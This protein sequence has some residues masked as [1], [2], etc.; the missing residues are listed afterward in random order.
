VIAV[1]EAARNVVVSGAQP[2]AISDCLNFGNPEKPEVMWQFQQAVGG[3]RDACIALATPVVSGNVSFYNDTEGRS[4]PPTPTIAMVGLL[5][6]VSRCLT[7]GFRRAGDLVVLA[8]RT[9]EELGGSEYLAVIHG[10]VQGA[11]PWIDLG[12]EKR[13]QELILEAAAEG[14]L[15]SAHDVA[16]G[17]LAVALAECC[18]AS[19]ERLGARIELEQSM[20]ADV[21][22]FAESQSRI[23]VTVDRQSWPR[24]R[25]RAQ[26]YGVPVEPIGEVGG[27]RLEIGDW[28][29]RSVGELAEIWEG[30]LERALRVVA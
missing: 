15:H 14:M 3:I 4:I 25:D 26:R 2:L 18:L 19:Q 5:D 27:I 9:H 12:L 17:G 7:Q 8:G 6:D 24:L 21:L 11:P 10:L 13:L 28:I 20:R 23:L 16:E 30:A 29:D 22:L 1:C